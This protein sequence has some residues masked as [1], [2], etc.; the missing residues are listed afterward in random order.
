M[1]SI[2]SLIIDLRNQKVILVVETDNKA[3]KN[4][5]GKFP[6]GYIFELKLKS[7]AVN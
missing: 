3:V 7:M 1:K 4:N 5:S 2:E 6:R